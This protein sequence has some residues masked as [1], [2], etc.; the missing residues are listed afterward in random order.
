MSVQ[1]KAERSPADEKPL[2][3][4]KPGRKPK[5]AGVQRERKTYAM[6]GQT[7]ETPDEVRLAVPAVF[8]MLITSSDG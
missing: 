3:N 4:G 2:E 1:V 8:P 7:R 5:V 6:P